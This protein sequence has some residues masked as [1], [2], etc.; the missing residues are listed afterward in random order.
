MALDWPGVGAATRVV[1]LSL[2]AEAGV[3]TLVALAVTLDEP[4][5]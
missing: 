3:V 2:G 4:A 1:L 5:N